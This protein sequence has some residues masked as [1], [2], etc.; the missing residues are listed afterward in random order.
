MVCHTPFLSLQST[1]GSG[2]TGFLGGQTK[3]N[4]TKKKQ[5]KKYFSLIKYLVGKD[6]DV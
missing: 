6:P 1:Y 5:Q 4:P 3:P 2:Y